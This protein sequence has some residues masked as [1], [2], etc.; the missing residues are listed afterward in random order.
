MLVTSNSKYHI[1]PDKEYFGYYVGFTCKIHE[2]F[3]EKMPVQ[4]K[5]ENKVSL[6]EW[7]DISP[8]DED[9]TDTE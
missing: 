2:F 5:L 9:T 8:E 3:V 6:L 7:V 1:I 4:E